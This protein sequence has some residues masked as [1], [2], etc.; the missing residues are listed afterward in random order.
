MQLMTR[1]SVLTLNRPIIVGRKPEMPRTPDSFRQSAVY[2]SAPSTPTS[3]PTNSA[4]W[5]QSAKEEPLNRQ[6]HQF[7]PHLL[8]DGPPR[9]AVSAITP[10]VDVPQAPMNKRLQDPSSCSS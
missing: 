8:A 9:K 4:E 2:S 7:A 1:I 5:S 3:F 10:V 6:A